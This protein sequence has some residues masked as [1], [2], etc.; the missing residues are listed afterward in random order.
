MAGL[1]DGQEV[2]AERQYWTDHHAAVHQTIGRPWLD[3]KP[4]WEE[5]DR[6]QRVVRNERGVRRGWWLLGELLWRWDGAEQSRLV[7]RGGKRSVRGK[8]GR[9]GCL[10]NP[11]PSLGK[12]ISVAGSIHVSIETTNLASDGEFGVP[13]SVVFQVGRC[14]RSGPEYMIFLY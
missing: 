8:N 9:L 1:G 14:I 7:N 5:R 2:V 6:I 13:P 11:F 10:R 12:N 3:S 4:R